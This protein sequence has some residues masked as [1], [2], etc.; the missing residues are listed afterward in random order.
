MGRDTDAGMESRETQRLLTETRRAKERA[1]AVLDSLTRTRRGEGADPMKRLTG[2]SSM[3]NAI[4]ATRRI[5][6]TLERSITDLERR[7]PSAERAHATN[8]APNGVSSN[9]SPRVTVLGEGGRGAA[10]G[11]AR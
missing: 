4:E 2:K 6:D 5:I 1:R 10:T 3:D 8:G 11:A 7:L 9:G